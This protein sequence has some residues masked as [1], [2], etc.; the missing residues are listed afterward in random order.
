MT[1]AQYAERT[2][3]AYRMHAGRAAAN[4][5]RAQ[6]KPSVFLKRFAAGLPPGG[7]AL[8][9][10][11]GIGC[12]M[13]WLRR[14]GFRVEGVDGTLDFAEAARRRNPG[15][16]VIGLPFSACRLEG[17]RYDG[18]WSNA[19]LIHLPPAVFRSELQ[20]LRRALVP[21]GR[22]GLTLAWGRRKG[23]LTG[24]WIPGRYFAC[25]TLPEALRF[26]KGW[27]V[28]EARTA[29]GEERSGRWIRILAEG[30]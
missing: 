10:G 2:L 19:A 1:G 5:A 28:L 25:Y 23:V 4:W 14:L 11:C 18:I 8:D 6:R 21:G 29:V 7:R 9:Y 12:E 13:A 26:L 27:R 20:K 30:Q 3:V 17:G 22:L 16:R 24:D 15:V